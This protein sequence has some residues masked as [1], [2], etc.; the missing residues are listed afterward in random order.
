MKLKIFYF[1]S[2]N[3]K[4]KQNLIR[5]TGRN[6]FLNSTVICLCEYTVHIIIKPI[7]SIHW[8]DFYS[9]LYTDKAVKILCKYSENIEANMLGGKILQYY[10][11]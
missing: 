2:S 3:I 11:N 10:F 1:K 5:F 6:F 7:N 8:K 9:I 4:K